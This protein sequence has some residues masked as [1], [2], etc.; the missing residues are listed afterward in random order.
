[1]S[2]LIN[3]FFKVYGI[4]NA[5]PILTSGNSVFW[6]KDTAGAIYI[7]VRLDGSMLYVGHDMKQALLNYLFH[8]ENLCYIIEHTHEIIR[9]D[10]LEQ[11]VRELAKSYEPIG[12][13]V[14]TKEMLKPLKRDSKGNGKKK[15]KKKG[16]RR[17]KIS[18]NDMEIIPFM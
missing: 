4:S 7:W 15:G 9:V 8:Q 18:I 6:L 2:C 10:I 12:R 13:I 3:N 1:M 17:I 16:K 14:V 5:Q 11:E